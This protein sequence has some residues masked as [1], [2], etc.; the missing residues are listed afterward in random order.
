MQTEGAVLREER[1]SKASGSFRQKPVHCWAVAAI[2]ETTTVEGA[3]TT[4]INM[5]ITWKI[6]KHHGALGPNCLNLEV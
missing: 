3:E 5:Q 1:V 6:H 4:K 2:P